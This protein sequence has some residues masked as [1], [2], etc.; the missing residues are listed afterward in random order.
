MKLKWSSVLCC[1]TLTIQE[2]GKLNN[3]TNK[4]HILISSS[5]KQHRKTAV[6]IA[7]GF[8]DGRLTQL[9]KFITPW[10]GISDL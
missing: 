10:I 1:V 7:N 4:Q 6:L 2:L 3:V 5:L 8:G 9:M